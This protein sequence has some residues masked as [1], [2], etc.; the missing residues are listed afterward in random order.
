VSRLSEYGP[1][2]PQTW[3]PV[4]SAA[5][6]RYVDHSEINEDLARERANRRITDRALV[7]AAIAELLATEDIDAEITQTLFGDIEPL[8]NRVHGY[9]VAEALREIQ[10]SD[11]DEKPMRLRKRGLL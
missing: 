3:G 4:T 1:G 7:K 9:F 6:P 10:E 2:D 5:D 8:T 11:E